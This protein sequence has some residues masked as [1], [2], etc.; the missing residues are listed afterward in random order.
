MKIDSMCLK[1]T[2]Q[3]AKDIGSWC[4]IFSSAT[5]LL[6]AGVASLRQMLH[7]YSW[8]SISAA[9]ADAESMQHQLQRCSISCRDAVSA[10]EIQHQ[11]QRYRT[12]CSN[13]SP[14]PD[15]EHYWLC[16]TREM[17]YQPQLQHQLQGWSEMQHHVQRCNTTCSDATPPAKMQHQLQR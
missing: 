13:V 6:A 14:A 10:A 17:Q 8:F 9:G 15:V 16:S 12:S 7:L 5:S 11:L 2:S 3:K 4:C 1:R